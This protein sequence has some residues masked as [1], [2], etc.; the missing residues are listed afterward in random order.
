MVV[1]TYTVEIG[2]T[3]TLPMDTMILDTGRL[4]QSIL[5]GGDEQIVWTDISGFVE[6]IQVSYGKQDILDR[7]EAATASVTLGNADGRFSPENPASPFFGQLQV[8]KPIRIRMRHV[9]EVN[10]FAGDIQ[11]YVADP[12]REQPTM[13]IDASDIDLRL[14]NTEL[15]NVVPQETTGARINRVL[16][17]IG[18]K[19]YRDID[20]GVALLDARELDVLGLNHVQDV[21]KIELGTFWTQTPVTSARSVIFRDRNARIQRPA[22]TTAQATFGG[23]GFGYQGLEYDLSTDLLANE[24][25]ATKLD[26]EGHGTVQIAEDEES[27]VAFGGVWTL[28]FESTHFGSD[29]EAAGW[30]AEMLGRRRE[31]K[32]RLLSLTYDALA[33]GGELAAAMLRTIN[34]RVAVI[35]P[36]LAISRDFYIEGVKH[37]IRADPR[38]HTVSYFVSP[39]PPSCIV[40]LNDSELGMLDHCVLGVA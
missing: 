40:T 29:A 19:G 23:D 18:F 14:K 33:S 22:S 25:R 7:Y 5:G 21:V 20:T 11:R 24:V 35:H 34:D 31:P 27:Q 13:I 16:D 10:L 38:A 15:R 8:G 17:H 4:D 12:R 30:A 28:S 6:D 3:T 1:P 37:A 36:N 9:V 26:E 2:F 39:A 32:G